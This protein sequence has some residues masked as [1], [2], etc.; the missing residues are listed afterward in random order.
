ME[1]DCLENGIHYFN[2]LYET[3]SFLALL[4]QKKG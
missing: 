4:V 3:V 2:N 1:E